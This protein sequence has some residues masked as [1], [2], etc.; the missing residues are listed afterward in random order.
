MGTETDA[1]WWPIPDSW[2]DYENSLVCALVPHFSYYI[3][4]GSGFPI[5]LEKAI[6]YPNPY[7]ADKHAGIGIRFDKLT[8]NFTIKIFNIA[9]ELVR[10]IHVS[11]P[12]ESWDACNSES[13][14]VT[15]GIYIYLI[16]DIVGNKKTG[17]VGVIR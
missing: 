8:E 3:L 14:K 9:G 13:E 1:I 4:M 15:S 5:T 17:K 11:S 6:A 7:Y 12:Q 10:E 2:I 16:T